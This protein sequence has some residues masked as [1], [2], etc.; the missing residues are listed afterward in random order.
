M[1]TSLILTFSYRETERHRATMPERQRD[2]EPADQRERQTDRQTDR[3]RTDIKPEGQRETK[4]QIARK[5]E[6][7]RENCTGK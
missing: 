1:V 5:R 2:I 4:K 3:Q 7:K 6:V